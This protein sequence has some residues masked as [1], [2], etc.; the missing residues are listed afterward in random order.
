MTG[1]H[2]KTA[3]RSE[4]DVFSLDVAMSHAKAMKVFYG[5]AHLCKDLER[6]LLR[7]PVATCQQEVKELT[8]SQELENNVDVLRLLYDVDQRR[9]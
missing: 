2:L 6:L 7:E 5:E 4:D 8:A 1:A 9:N 3:A